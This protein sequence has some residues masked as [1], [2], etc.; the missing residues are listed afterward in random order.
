[1]EDCRASPRRV[2][3]FQRFYITVLIL[4]QIIRT[5]LKNQISV[6]KSQLTLTGIIL[7]NQP[8]VM[9]KCILNLTNLY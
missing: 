6:I 8:C 2:T 5:L 7:K 1:M 3:F 4:F 9:F